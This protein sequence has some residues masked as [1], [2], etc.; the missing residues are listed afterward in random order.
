MERHPEAWKK[1]VEKYDEE[2]KYRVDFEKFLK[3]E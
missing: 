3:E 2:R 1:L